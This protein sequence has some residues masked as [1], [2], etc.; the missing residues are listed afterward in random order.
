MG[1]PSETDKWQDRCFINFTEN[2]LPHGEEIDNGKEKDL[3]KIPSLAFKII[4]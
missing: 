1:K 2:I 3:E 4:D